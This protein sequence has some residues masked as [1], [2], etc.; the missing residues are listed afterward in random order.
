MTSRPLNLENLQNFEECLSSGLGIAQYE[1]A[2]DRRTVD[3]YSSGTCTKADAPAFATDGEHVPE[4]LV[5]F[6]TAFSA[7]DYIDE[8]LY[9]PKE[10]ALADAFSALVTPAVRAIISRFETASFDVDVNALVRNIG[11]AFYSKLFSMSVRAVVLEL[12]AAQSTGLLKGETSEERFEFF[13]S[14]L[15]NPDFSR[16][17]LM[18]YPLL[19][20]QAT[21]AVTNWQAALI[22]FADRLVA[23]AAEIAGVFFGTDAPGELTRLHLSAGDSH[24]QGRSVVIA[25]FDNGARS[26]VYKPRSLAVDRCYAGLVSWL[27]DLGLEPALTSVPILERENYGWVQH[28]AVSPCKDE[29]EV[30]Q[31]YRRQGANTALLYFLK[32]TDIHSEN[33]IAAGSN[34]II[35][36][37][38]ALFHPSFQAPGDITATAQAQRAIEQSA[39]ATGLLPLRAPR[40]TSDDDW[41]DFSGM[42]GAEDREIPIELPTWVGLGSDQM[43]MQFERDVLV[44]DDNLP[45][46]NGERIGPKAYMEAIVQGFTEVYEL[47]CANRGVL[48]APDGPVAAFNDVEVRVIVRS[49]FLYLHTLLESYHPD[50]L[51]Q[52]SAREAYFDTLWDDEG[53]KPHLKRLHRAERYDL[54]NCDVPVFTAKPSSTTLWTSTGEQVTQAFDVSVMTE[55]VDRIKGAGPNDLAMQKF[56]I[57]ATLAE[58][59]D[60]VTTWPLLNQGEADCSARHDPLEIAIQ[61]GEQLLA[62][63]IRHDG[64]TSWLVLEESDGGNPTI[65]PA[66][67]DLYSGLPG[68]ALFLNCLGEA[69]GDTRFK[70]L[71]GETL[72]ELDRSLPVESNGEL[73]AYNG[74]VGVLYA[75]SKSDGGLGRDAARHAAGQLAAPGA[76]MNIDNTDVIAGLA[77]CV[78][79]LLSAEANTGDPV[80]FQQAR[81]AGEALISRLAHTPASDESF[82][83]DELSASLGLGHGRIGAALALARLG[84]RSGEQEFTDAAT[85]LSSREIARMDEVLKDSLETGVDLARSWCNGTSGFLLALLEIIELSP[86]AGGRETISRLLEPMLADP[87]DVTD[88]L[89]HG[90]LGSALIVEKAA[91]LGLVDDPAAADRLR[92]QTL[93]RIAENGIASGT[94]SGLHAP[95]LMDGLAGVGLGLLKLHA[96]D[97]A[98]DVLTLG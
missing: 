15:R 8:P 87:G 91:S 25:E 83:P 79:A 92:A 18:Q 98:P 36:D 81:A 35:V 56:V 63:A 59:D 4:W 71:A 72:S 69:T 29:Q 33:V 42:S 19:V 67:G 88:C 62:T 54:W 24:R 37:L 78:L 31:F 70:Q 86:R 45:I 43:R 66:G 14:C 90:S 55:V 40:G 53:D 1:D 60:G 74:A 47:F 64:G 41:L 89:C 75:L 28:I 26:I 93:S 7:R 13:V 50:F 3:T 84:A 51:L 11:D 32:G 68:I 95:G 5:A 20:R 96:P 58:F 52:A 9:G 12:A 80:L 97:A 48:L 76:F 10:I 21:V 34:P 94:V 85:A 73:G 17:I 23:D 61:I 46:L 44:D 65:A 38:E 30:E 39:A 22:E 77:G 6:E 16:A 2:V 27:N 82:T 57:R 49:T